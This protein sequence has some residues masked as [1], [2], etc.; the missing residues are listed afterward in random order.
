MS[1]PFLDRIERGAQN[2]YAGFRESAPQQQAQPQQSQYPQQ[3][4]G[5]QGYGQQGY[6]YQQPPAPSGY[7]QQGQFGQQYPQPGQQQVPAPYDDGR[8]VT[9]DDVMM[10]TAT[11]FAVLMVTA[12]P[13]WFLAPNF[14]P[15]FWGVGLIATLGL[16]FAIYLKKTISVPLILAYAAFQGLFVGSISRTYALAFD[17][18]NTPIFQG[19]V[20]QA[21]LAT[22]CVFGAMFA[23]YKTGVIKVTQKFRSI[24]S[25]AILGYFVFAMI[26][27]GYAMLTNTPFG[28]G[29]TTWLGVG[30]SL[31]A[32]GLAAVTLTLDFDSIEKAVAARAPEKFSWLLAHG[33]LV[34]IIWLYLEILR[35]LARMRD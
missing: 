8:A 12:I 15:V 6:G 9:L 13:A 16:G 7:G 29:G 19:I 4:Y 24:V 17:S 11:L 20:V 5:Q 35:L 3:G 23:L 22:L 26:N 27:L 21:V 2:G 31:F 28:F 10:K 18:E 34:T 33:L 32:T 25:M 1:N 14:G 30:I